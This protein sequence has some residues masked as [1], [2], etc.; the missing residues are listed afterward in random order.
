M[1]IVF[2]LIVVAIIAL[3]TTVFAPISVD[4][5]IMESRTTAPSSMWHFSTSTPNLNRLA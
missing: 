1:W 4:F 5:I 3:F 2:D